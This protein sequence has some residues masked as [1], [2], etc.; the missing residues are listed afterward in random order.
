[1]NI[2]RPPEEL[3]RPRIVE[4]ASA[5]KASLARAEEDYAAGRVIPHAK[6]REWLKTWGTPDEHPAPPEWL[7]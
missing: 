5:R 1:M 7:E 2:Q 3:V 4:S 6:M